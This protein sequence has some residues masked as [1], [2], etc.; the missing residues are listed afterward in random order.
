MV[1]AMAVSIC[2][3]SKQGFEAVVKIKVAKRQRGLRK[4]SFVS[5]SLF[6]FLLADP[7]PSSFLLFSAPT[8]AMK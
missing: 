8:A 1:Q 6:L 2:L 4:H 5:L 7:S 3:P